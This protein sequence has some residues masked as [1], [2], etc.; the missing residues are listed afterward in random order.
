MDQILSHFFEE[1]FTQTFWIDRVGKCRGPC[2]SCESNTL[3]DIHACKKSCTGPTFSRVVSVVKL[4]QFWMSLAR[5]H[6]V[7][8]PLTQNM[9]LVFSM[10][11]SPFRFHDLMARVYSMFLTELSNRVQI[12]LSGDSSATR[13]TVVHLWWLP[14]T[15]TFNFISRHFSFSPHSGNMR[16]NK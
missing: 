6:A 14:L 3:D 11:W 9:Q 10:W 8:Y 16:F 7:E 5:I 2:F 1:C 4:K 13:R 12:N 15:K